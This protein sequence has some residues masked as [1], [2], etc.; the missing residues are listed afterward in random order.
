MAER[1]EQALNALRP[2]VEGT[3]NERIT[4]RRYRTA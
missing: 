2:F 4:C 3:T 1:E